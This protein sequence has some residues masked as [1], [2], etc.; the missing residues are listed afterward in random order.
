MNVDVAQSGDTVAEKRLQPLASFQPS[1]NRELIVG[2]AFGIVGVIILIFVLIC[3]SPIRTT[4]DVARRYERCVSSMS[5][6]SQLYLVPFDVLPPNFDY[7]SREVEVRAD[8]VILKDLRLLERYHSC[9][10]GVV[11]EAYVPQPEYNPHIY[12]TIPP[13]ER[14]PYKKQASYNPMFY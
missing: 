7:S 2:V 1:E 3:L 8:Y 6:K 5:T 4:Q 11:N 13:L 12:G 14:E 10:G 9:D